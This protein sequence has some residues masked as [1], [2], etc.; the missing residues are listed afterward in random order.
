MSQINASTTEQILLAVFLNFGTFI[1]CMAIAP[2][3]AKYG[4]IFIYRTDIVLMSIGG[5]LCCLP[6]YII[7]LGLLL[8]GIGIGA[9]I[10]ITNT[11]FIESIPQTKVKYL[12]I[13]NMSWGLGTSLGVLIA[14]IIE[15]VWTFEMP[16]W[17]ALIWVTTIITWLAAYFRWQLLET[18]IY[19]H[20]VSYNK[21]Y[22]I[23]NNIAKINGKGSYQANFSLYREIET[24]EI[25]ATGSIF[26][27]K[28]LKVTVF[29]TFI[30][31]FSTLAYYALLYFT[32]AL[33][34]TTSVMLSYLIVL[35]QQICKL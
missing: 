17:N 12:T 27:G 20:K 5:I 26:K 18:P 13:L 4:R 23:I 24:N 10:S 1:G 11:I 30:Y 9:D 7:Y 21:V 8:V 28:L 19:L 15:L 14:I 32:T 31:F 22:D 29:L 6:F 34:P 3:I 2:L 25:K 35:A 16:S 33:I